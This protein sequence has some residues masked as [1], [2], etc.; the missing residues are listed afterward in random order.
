MV[1]GAAGEAA[2]GAENA[3]AYDAEPDG[4]AVGAGTVPGTRGVGVGGA[5]NDGRRR[6]GG[7]GQVCEPRVVSD[8]ELGERDDAEDLGKGGL[9]GEVEDARAGGERGD[10]LVHGRLAGAAEKDEG[11][12]SC[13]RETGEERGEALVWPALGLV[14][15]GGDVGR[16]EGAVG[17]SRFRHLRAR[18]AA[19]RLGNGP[20]GVGDAGHRD[21]R[22]GDETEMAEELV[23][24]RRA[25]ERN[26]MREEGRAQLSPV[27]PAFRDP[28]AV[29]DPRRC[30]AAGQ[31][32][33]A[34]ESPPV[35]LGGQCGTTGGPG[36]APR[37]FLDENLVDLGKKAVKGGDPRP[38]ENG[39]P[40]LRVVRAQGAKR[41]KRDDDVTDP[42][43]G[44]K[45]N[46][47]SV[48]HNRRM[49]P[50]V[51]VVFMVKDEV[52]RLGP[53]L[54]SVGWAE[55]VLVADT[56]STDGTVELA[57]AAGARVEAIPWEGYVASRN[58]ALALATHDWVLVLDAD[59]RVSPI[60]AEEVRR[61][62]E[63]EDEVAAFRM[64][65]LSHI[66]AQ[67]IRHGVWSPDRKLRLGL[68]SRGL[69]AGGGR[70]H[71]R[72][73]VDGPVKDLSSPI[74]HFPYRDVADAVRKNT[75]YARLSALD[76]FDR[77][78]RGHILPVFFRPP[79][80]FLR[81]WVLKRGFLDG[82]AGVGVALLHAWYYLLRA[83][84]LVEESE[85]EKERRGR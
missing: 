25:R 44:T 37:P 61:A 84:F 72:I 57:R 73:E 14:G 31:E 9:P 60:L 69:R 11:E 59:E 42:V 32:N 39:N 78:A 2:G 10:A 38:R 55:E 76:R 15:E 17:N 18:R 13:R 23:L 8:E 4:A 26:R 1:E 21:A 52:D 62:V 27:A 6:P 33:R 45:E 68:R 71:E 51:S 81:S 54:A 63:S 12:I 7:V 65:R 77:G 64:P 41:G 79:L 24:T 50:A 58:R 3:L 20:G 53:S 70:V 48:Q 28:G 29:R 16:G 75:V 43:G 30:E 46:L 47:H 19:E 34:V 40:V 67:P 22:R 74:L 82:R 49:R 66:G 36:M 35:Q 85:R 83:A 80:E 56:G 5:E